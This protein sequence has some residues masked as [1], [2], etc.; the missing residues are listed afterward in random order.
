MYINIHIKQIQD[1]SKYDKLKRILMIINKLYQNYLIMIYVLIQ[2][3]T[4][5]RQNLVLLFYQDKLI[6]F[7]KL[8]INEYE[9]LFVYNI[10]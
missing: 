6:L 3:E 2:Q 9:Y 4:T 10:I 8:N 5:R 7:L 1:L